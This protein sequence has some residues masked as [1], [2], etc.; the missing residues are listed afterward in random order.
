MMWIYSLG[1]AEGANSW[2]N[3]EGA[4]RSLLDISKV[5]LRLGIYHNYQHT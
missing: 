2:H 1:S 3:G 4:E 5:V